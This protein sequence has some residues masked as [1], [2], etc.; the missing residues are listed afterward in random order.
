MRTAKQLLAIDRMYQSWCVI[1]WMHG[2]IK[3]FA[4]GTILSACLS[5]T[6]KEKNQNN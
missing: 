1:D 4:Y 2:N 6:S 3:Y 5:I